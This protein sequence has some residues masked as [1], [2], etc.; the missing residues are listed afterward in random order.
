MSHP[1]NISKLHTDLLIEELLKRVNERDAIKF[2]DIEL[3]RLADAIIEAKRK[4]R[5]E[6]Q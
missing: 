5:E 4:L 1:H 6:N 2:F 3:N